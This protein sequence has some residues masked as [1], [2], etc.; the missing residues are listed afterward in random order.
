MHGEVEIT[1]RP[2]LSMEAVDLILGNNLA[3]NPEWRAVIPPVVKTTPTLSAEG[4][5]SKIF[6]MFLSPVW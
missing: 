6:L 2:P 5:T 4:D 1:L 3:R